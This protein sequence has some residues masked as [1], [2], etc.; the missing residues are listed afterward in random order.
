MKIK[1]SLKKNYKSMVVVA[2]LMPSSAC[3]G[4]LYTRLFPWTLW[5]VGNIGNLIFLTWHTWIWAICDFQRNIKGIKISPPLVVLSTHC[6][7]TNIKLLP[8]WTF[9]RFFESESHLCAH[10]DVEVHPFWIPIFWIHCKIV[11]Q[12]NTWG[13]MVT[14]P[15]I[16]TPFILL[17]NIFHGMTHI[18][19]TVKN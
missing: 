7:I 6:H 17:K 4:S 19:H 5:F 18:T 11:P 1:D 14:N 10:Q 2:C 16:L 8:P 9:E 15:S 3:P 13:Q 12:Q